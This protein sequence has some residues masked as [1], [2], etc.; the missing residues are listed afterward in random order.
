MQKTKSLILFI[1]IFS[2]TF[3]DSKLFIPSIN[4]YTGEGIATIATIRTLQ[5]YSNVHTGKFFL[6]GISLQDSKD[7]VQLAAD[8]VAETVGKNVFKEKLKDKYGIINEHSGR[9]IIAGPSGGI[10]Y[11]LLIYSLVSE[12][13]FRKDY[14]ISGSGVL[15]EKGNIIHVEGLE[16]KITAAS[17]AGATLFLVPYSQKLLYETNYPELEKQLEKEGTPIKIVEIKTIDDAIKVVFHEENKIIPSLES[18]SMKELSYE[19]NVKNKKNIITLINQ[20]FQK[21]HDRLKKVSK[22]Q[23]FS[24]EDRE[25][26]KTALDTLNTIQ[27]YVKNNNKYDY[28]QDFYTIIY[29]ELLT[30]TQDKDTKTT[31]TKAEQ[32][33]NEDKKVLDQLPKTFKISELNYLRQTSEFYNQ[34]ARSAIKFQEKI[35]TEGKITKTPYLTPNIPTTMT[36]EAQKNLKKNTKYIK[37]KNF[38]GID[39]ETMTRVNSL[40]LKQI[41]KK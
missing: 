18:A 33:N 23:E 20:H 11:F 14:V 41:L 16:Q 4:G 2:I 32:A 6:S 25:G 10:G 27:N 1:L 21:T 24:P 8:L 28:M 7:A 37:N 26:A 29:Y 12:K 22:D 35:I 31:L 5:S 17:K 30:E 34:E 38:N 3:A 36:P 9:S 19:F 15:D 13:D 40:L 39:L